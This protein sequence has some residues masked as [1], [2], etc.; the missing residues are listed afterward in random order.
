MKKLIKIS[1][2]FFFLFFLVNEN[3]CAKE[4]I[5][6][7]FFHGDGCPHCAL[8]E[9]FLEKVEKKYDDIDIVRYEVWYNKENQELMQKTSEKFGVTTNGVP[10]TIVGSTY[11]IGYADGDEVKLERIINYYRKN[12][13]KYID[14]VDKIK[15]NTLDYE[16]VDN[17]T[18]KD[19]KTD[20]DT[21][22]KVPVI[23]KVNLKNTSIWIAAVVIGFIDG[24]NPCAMWVLLFLISMIITMKNRKRQW[25]LGLTFLAASA[26][27]Y[28]AI[29]LSWI[30][31]I[32]NISTSIIFRNIIAI[33]GLV[34]AFI[35][36]KNY[37][38][39]RKKDD[40]CVVVDAKK[41][42]KILEKIK[43]FTSEKSLLLA[44]IGVVGLAISVNVVELACSAGLPLMFSQI[45]TINNISGISAFMYTFV[46]ILFFLID[47]IIIFSVA[48]LTTKVSG[49]STKY[50]KYS[51]LIGGIL[52][53][54][55]GILLIIKP[56]WLMFNFN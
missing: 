18:V 8:E 41:R 51:H 23:G 38:D 36:I 15:N 29:M 14:N 39:E 28:M 34:G 5:K 12:K 7:Y 44:L 20:K 56:E 6:L 47:D 35:N 33:V 30:N 37:L 3:V 11:K 55:I 2:V 22:I 50:N 25:V 27:I 45:L 9:K 19:K 17:F 53:F 46:Y 4:K 13:D 43:K 1:V 40:G 48:M 42:K 24:F 49:I 32:V 52:M 10:L 31:V 26:L 54:I 16:I 21:T